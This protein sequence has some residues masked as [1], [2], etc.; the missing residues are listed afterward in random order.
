MPVLAQ[1]PTTRFFLGHHCQ[2]TRSRGAFVRVKTG[3]IGEDLVRLW[4]S[5][6]SVTANPVQRD[7]FGWDFCF[8]FRR[9]PNVATVGPLDLVAPEA[10]AFVQVKT[11]A[12]GATREDVTLANWQRMV[13]DPY[14][15]FFVR[16]SLDDA[17]EPDRV[18]LIHVGQQW[19]E[20]VLKRLRELS[21]DRP[22]LNEVTMALT[23]SD[24][25]SVAQPFGTNLR[26]AILGEV[27]TLSS[28]I[29][30]K[31]D[32]IQRAG[33][34]EFPFEATFTT[35][36]R[37]TEDYE[38]LV[39]FAIGLT[40][41]LPISS[42]VVKNTRFGIAQ[43][44]KEHSDVLGG[45]MS[46]GTDGPPSVATTQL[47]FTDRARATSLTHAFNTYIPT[48]MFGDLPPEHFKA[49]FASS[50]ISVVVKPAEVT[51][52]LSWHFSQE[53][54]VPLSELASAIELMSLCGNA[55]NGI[56]ISYDVGGKV[57]PLGHHS[58]ALALSP[59]AL[60]LVDVVRHATFLA[61]HLSLDMTIPVLP[62]DL[63]DRRSRLALMRGM[64]D[65]SLGPIDISIVVEN[66]DASVAGKHTAIVLPMTTRL[67]DYVVLVL[68]AYLGPAVW[69][70]FRSNLIT[71]FAPT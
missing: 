31:A 13:K 21:D 10:T 27:G 54:P 58:S 52:S 19:I 66:V 67:G 64:F 68:V 41:S 20:R 5:Q 11:T 59:D 36:T 32:V 56:G 16:V 57:I 24:A 55:A 43:T 60:R 34:S 65:K 46:F 4:A 35:P 62:A 17:G 39:D 26:D 12:S 9:E 48:M 49:R 14:P 47:I 38:R 30:K 45:T 61:K 37:T 2:T 51:M 71:R 8:Q 29:A 23:W 53:H 25:E 40:G 6:A 70:E 22:N 1:H 15:W 7:E 28:Y 44:V 69:C 50:T 42:F 63:D 18:Y 3:A 33:F